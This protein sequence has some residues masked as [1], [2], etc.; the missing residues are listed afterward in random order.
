MEY[1]SMCAMCTDSFHDTALQQHQTH[2]RL[3][4]CRLPIPQFYGVCCII[5]LYV[6]TN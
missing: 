2:I 4:Q 3:F 1:D 5:I 6:W